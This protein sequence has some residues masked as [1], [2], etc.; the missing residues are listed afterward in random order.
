MAI[1]VPVNLE[2][3]GQVRKVGS[4][5]FEIRGVIVN[6]VVDFPQNDAV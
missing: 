5:D 4:E 6:L 3:S 1:G 2:P